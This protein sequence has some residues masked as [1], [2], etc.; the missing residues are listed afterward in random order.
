MTSPQTLSRDNKIRMF[1]ESISLLVD[2]LTNKKEKLDRID[3]RNIKNIVDELKNWK[4]S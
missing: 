3:S 4:Q 2:L 1:K